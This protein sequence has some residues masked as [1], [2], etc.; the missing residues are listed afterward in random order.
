MLVRYVGQRVLASL[1]VVLGVT[2]V[3]FLVMHLTA[4]NYVP[5][6]EVSLETRPEDAQRL[7]QQLGLDQPLYV[8]YWTWLSGIVFRGDFGRSLIDNST[9]MSHVL[10]RLPN[11]LLLTA[12]AIVLG[13][14]VS[15]PMGIGAAV[16]RGRRI[17]DFLTVLSTAGVAVPQFWLGLLLILVFSVSFHRWGL[18]WLPSSGAHD[19][20]I[21]N[22]DPLDRLAHLIMPASVLAFFY[23]SIWSR[24]TRSS[25][26]EVLSQ[27]YVRTARAKGMAERRVNFVH[28]LRNAVVPL[29]TLV[30]LELPGLV[31]GGL[32]VEVVFGWPGIGRLAYERAVDYDYTMVLGITTFAA[33]LV[34]AGNLVADVLYGILDPRIRY[35]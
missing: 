15:I 6:L 31:A 33:F 22:F 3:T 26:I 34:V 29:V 16:R 30:G 12:T 5:G 10:D 28:A 1:F 24:F 21:L 4:G 27:D 8:Q 9:V 35:G 11:T 20:L 19:V 23:V 32:I 17:D 14:A 13:I 25:M 2:V 7:R 18:P